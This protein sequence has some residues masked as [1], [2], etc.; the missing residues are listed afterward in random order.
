[1]STRPAQ[2]AQVEGLDARVQMLDTR[3][4]ERLDRISASLENVAK[5]LD[6]FAIQAA[7]LNSGMNELKGITRQVLAAI[8]ADREVAKLQSGNV[9]Q[10]VALAA[11][12]QQTINTLLQKLVA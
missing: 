10:M 4:Y 1:M 12:Q 6:N 11:Q 2:A 5:S 9:Q 8:E 3:I 7:Q